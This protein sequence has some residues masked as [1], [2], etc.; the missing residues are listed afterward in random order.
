MRAVVEM[1]RRG[2]G[3]AVSPDEMYILLLLFSPGLYSNFFVQ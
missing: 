1:G 2:C 3:I